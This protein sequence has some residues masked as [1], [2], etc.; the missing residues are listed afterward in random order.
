MTLGLALGLPWGDLG[1]RLG[2]GLLLNAFVYLLNDCFDVQID[3]GAPGRD[4]ERT[5]F[6]ASHRRAGWGAVVALGAVNLAVGALHSSGLTI[7][8]LATAALIAVYSGWLKRLPV[9]DVVAMAGWGTTMAMVGFP[10]SSVP[11]WWLAGLLGILCM[12]TELLQVI[13]DEPSD[14]AAGIRTSAVVLGPVACAWL[15]RVLMAAAAAYTAAF[16]HRWVG[17]A[18]LLGCA[19][20]LSSERAASSWDLLRVLFGLVWLAILFLFYRAGALH[21]WLGIG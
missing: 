1:W 6:L 15:G 10:P 3:L 9:I 11:G 18:L 14:R 12:V 5:R 20:P 19:V 8:F 13:R 2:F 21:G 7:C 16:L 17:L 4:A